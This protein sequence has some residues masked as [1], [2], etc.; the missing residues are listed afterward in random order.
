MM[1]LGL[2]LSIN[3]CRIDIVMLVITALSESLKHGVLMKFRNSFFRE[4]LLI[5]DA[6]LLE[7]C[8]IDPLE[9]IDKVNFSSFNL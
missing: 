7:F 3:S 4:L 6:Y 2:G 5:M 8:L 9:L 1:L